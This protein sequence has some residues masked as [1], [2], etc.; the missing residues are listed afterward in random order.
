[1]R[2]LLALHTKSAS[3]ASC[4]AKFDPVGL[5]LENFDVMGRWRTEYRGL[6]AGHRVSGIDPAGHDFSYT[7]ANTVDASGQLA[8][9]RGFKDIHALKAILKANP[10]QLA[11]NLLY[12]FTLYA[13][14]T[15]A[16]FADRREIESM[17]DACAKDGYRVR[18]LLHVLVQSKIF[19][20]QNGWVKKEV[21]K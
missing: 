11:R 16:R 18:D 13:T 4:H 5:A 12:Q 7:L 3:C 14:G 21:T 6:E 19:L 9:G 10:R 15:P 8:D 1:M 2:D 20:G 17:L